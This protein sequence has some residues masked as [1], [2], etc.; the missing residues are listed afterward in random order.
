MLDRYNDYMRGVLPIVRDHLRMPEHK[1]FRHFQQHSQGYNLFNKLAHHGC[2]T[3]FISGGGP[4]IGRLNGELN[5][6]LS[7]IIPSNPNS[8]PKLGNWMAMDPE[9]AME[10]MSSH[11]QLSQNFGGIHV[12]FMQLSLAEV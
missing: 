9:L 6:T 11:P 4:T 12:V 5:F 10:S 1:L 7:D 3:D 2:A 8:R